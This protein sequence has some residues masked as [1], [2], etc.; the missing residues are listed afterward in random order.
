MELWHKNETYVGETN[1]DN[2]NFP[3]RKD[4]TRTELF[5]VTTEDGAVIRGIVTEV[6]RS[7]Y[8]GA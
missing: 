2:I 5:I 6:P 4:T 3:A 8:T 1:P 7:T